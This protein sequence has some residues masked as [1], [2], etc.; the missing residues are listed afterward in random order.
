MPAHLRPRLLG[1]H[2]GLLI[3]VL[4][5]AWLS[6][7]Q[8]GRWVDAGRAASVVHAAPGPVVDIASVVRPNAP[9]ASGD[10]GRRVSAVGTYA[11]GQVFLPGRQREGREGFWVMTPLR[12]ASGD[13]VAVVRGWVS[14]AADAA[15]SPP[16]G[17]VTVT[18]QL[19]EP[20]PVEISDDPL[21]P[22]QAN[23]ASPVVLSSRVDAPFYAGV[24]VLTAQTPATQRAPVPVRVRVQ[25]GG[26]G[27]AGL[28]NLAYAVQWVAFIALA[29]WFWRRLV[30][31][32]LD[33]D[34]RIAE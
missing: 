3:A 19:Q 31:D 34:V 21:P 17:R 24:L 12:L 15:T 8:Y 14:S 26:R 25:G 18:G 30:R 29:V 27:G 11:P 4:A 9:F 13:V 7:W 5:M 23:A 16:V 22:G 32:E 1:L 33:R 6:S 10:S 2:A 28:L 20:E